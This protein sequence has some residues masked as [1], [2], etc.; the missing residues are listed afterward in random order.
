MS[1]HNSSLFS[2]PLVTNYREC[3]TTISRGKMTKEK[4][5]SKNEDSLIANFWT[6]EPTVRYSEVRLSGKCK[7]FCLNL[8][9]EDAESPPPTRLK[10]VGWSSV[11][12]VINNYDAVLNSLEKTASEF[13]KK[14]TP[15]QTVYIPPFHRRK[16][17]S[18]L[19]DSAIPRWLE[20]FNRELQSLSEDRLRPRML[21][22]SEVVLSRL[23]SLR[24]EEHFNRLFESLE[25][26]IVDYD[27]TLL[28]FP[29]CKKLPSQ[30]NDGVDIC[31]K[32]T[33]KTREV[34]LR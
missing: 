12:S 27:L 4:I 15:K 33:S 19:C 29:H 25:K 34:V 26:C 18:T 11:V 2:V 13:A 16:Q 9:S 23:L 7:I 32:H 31:R 20:A 22:T 10:V 3:C 24:N 17:F 6:C 5:S 28:V 8:H 14:S 21:K 30:L 1:L